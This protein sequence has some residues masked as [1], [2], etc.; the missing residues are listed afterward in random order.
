[1]ENYKPKSFALQALLFTSEEIS[2]CFFREPSERELEFMSFF[3]TLQSLLTV[4]EYHQLCRR[5]KKGRPGYDLLTILGIQLLQLH[6][7]QPTMKETLLLLIEN[8]NL[9]DILSLKKVPSCSTVSRLSRQV[10]GIVN[11]QLIHHR[12]IQLFQKELDDRIVGNLS[13]DSTI[14]EAREKPVSSKKE[15]KNNASSKKRGPKKKGSSEERK[16]RAQ[17]ATLERQKVKYLR[18]SPQKNIKKLEKRCS[19]TAKQN[20]KGKL[21]WFVGYKAHLATDDFGIPIAYAVTGACVHDSQVAVPLMKMVY[22]RA[23]FYYALMDKGYINPQI[24][25][26]ANLIGRK[27]IIDQRQYKGVA[28][29]AQSEKI[30]YKARTTVER[31][32]SELKDGFLPNKLYRKKSHARYDIELSILLLTMKKV[33]KI[34]LLKDQAK[35]IA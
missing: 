29:M 34:L 11:P 4:K 2:C 31:T 12:L 30:R 10:E 5:Q 32:N 18:E 21:Q 27:V 25:A 1:M 24:N 35:A 13:I 20:S 23:D 33:K 22:K 15:I 28:P 6:F 8:S 9:R 16:Y 19:R 7:K 3:Q 17:Q 26:Y 14:I